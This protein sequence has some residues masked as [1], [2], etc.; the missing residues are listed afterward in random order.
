MNPFATLDN[1]VAALRAHQR[2]RLQ[3][4]VH[5]HIDEQTQAPIRAQVVSVRQYAPKGRVLA[6][7]QALREYGPMTAPE[8]ARAGRLPT[9]GV[10]S[11]MDIPCANGLAVKLSGKPTRWMAL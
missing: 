10:Y 5:Q 11:C 7:L 1:P 4:P 9:R 3:V 2:L 6:M 8:L